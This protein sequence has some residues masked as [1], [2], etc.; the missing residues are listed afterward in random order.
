MTACN[1]ILEFLSIWVAEEQAL[2]VIVIPDISCT[3][4]DFK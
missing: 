2:V 1:V 3:T 4:K